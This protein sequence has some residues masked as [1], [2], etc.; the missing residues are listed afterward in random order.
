[1]PRAEPPLK[2]NLRRGGGASDWEG[3]QSSRRFE[4]ARP[5]RK[6]RTRAQRRAEAEE[7]YAPAEPEE[8][9]AGRKVRV[10]PSVLGKTAS[11]LRKAERTFRGRRERPSEG[12]RRAWR[13]RSRDGG[14]GRTRGRSRPCPAGRSE[15][16]YGSRTSRIE[17][18]STHRR[19]V[20]RP[21]AGKVEVTCRSR[22]RSDRLGLT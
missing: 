5:S 10:S 14:R 6:A 7:G 11:G 8:S 13:C 15:S 2:P 21:A 17:K 22:A 16:A 19:D 18:R 3:R 9:A 4:R 1:M 20:H 12:G